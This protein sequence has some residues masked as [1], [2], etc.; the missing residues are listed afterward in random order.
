MDLSVILRCPHTFG[1]V[2]FVRGVK[3]D[4]VICIASY[5]F[6][7]LNV[8]SRH[9]DFLHHCQQIAHAGVKYLT[10]SRGVVPLDSF[11]TMLSALEN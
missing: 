1:H 2:A 6:F 5:V 3:I 9:G 11:K 4:T 8:N 10:S 7:L